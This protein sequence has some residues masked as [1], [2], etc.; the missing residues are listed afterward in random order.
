VLFRSLGGLACWA[1]VNASRHGDLLPALAPANAAWVLAIAA[2][3]MLWVVAVAAPRFTQGFVPFISAALGW[4]AYDTGRTGDVTMLWQLVVGA[5]GAFAAFQV[6]RRQRILPRRR[7]TG[8]A[9]V[10]RDFLRTYE[11]RT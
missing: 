5:V 3:F 11:A 2:L 4:A 1:I 9:R 7:P 6:A 8:S 10:V